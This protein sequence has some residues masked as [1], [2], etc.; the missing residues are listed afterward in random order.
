MSV[1]PTR[2]RATSSAIRGSG[3]PTGAPTLAAVF[4]LVAAR[5][6]TAVR[7]NI[8]TKLDPRRPEETAPPETIVERLLATIDAAG[9]A[10]APPSSRSTGAPC[11]WCSRPG[12][13]WRPSTC[14]PSRT[15]STRSRRR[16]PAPARGRPG[17]PRASMAARCRG[18][19]WRPVAPCGRPS[20]ATTDADLAEAKRLGLPV[21]VWTVNERTDMAALIDRGVDGIITDRPDILRDL[22]IARGMAVPAGR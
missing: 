18:W 12:R 14:P 1:G 20:G 17:S 7:F 22:M 8:E 4:A 9:M 13:R 6:D 15:S 16:S 5:G 11:A 3:A 19:W 10:G 21:V 2:P